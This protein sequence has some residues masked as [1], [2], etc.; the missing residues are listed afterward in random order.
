M[1]I[2]AHRGFSSLYPE[3]TM[4]AFKKAYEKGVYAIELDVHLSKNNELII[5]H[6]EKLIEQV[7]VMDLLKI[8]A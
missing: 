1:K 4:L 8:I 3:N 2:I 5:I 6:D 7:T